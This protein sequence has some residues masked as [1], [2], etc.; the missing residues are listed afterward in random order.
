MALEA[1][2]VVSISYILKD[3]NGEMVDQA[4]KEQPFI[5]LSGQNQILPNLE[6]KISEMVIGS[7]QKVVLTSEQGYGE[8]RE[9]AV[10]QVKRSEFP[11]KIDLQEGQRF[12]ADLGEGQHRPF[13][14]KSVSENKVTIDFNH[15]LAGVKLEFDIEL[16]DIRDATDEEIMHGHVHGPGDHKH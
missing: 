11:D 2:K 5:F 12:M 3:E 1:N 16:L 6:N 15:P 13:F 14:V 8:Y 7:Q 4:P 10:R 9:D